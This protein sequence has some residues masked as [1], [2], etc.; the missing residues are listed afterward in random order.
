M[1]LNEVHIDAITMNWISK[2]TCR[3]LFLLG[4]YKHKNSCWMQHN[5]NIHIENEVRQT[6]N[7]CNDQEL[8][9]SGNMS[10][11]FILYSMIGIVR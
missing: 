6:S 9:F 4:W 1:R 5:V 10:W 2:V 3:G 7:R 8:D 11:S